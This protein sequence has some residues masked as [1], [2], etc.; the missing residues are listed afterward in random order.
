MNFSIQQCTWQ[1]QKEHLTAIRQQVFIEGQNISLQDEYDGLD[2]AAEHFLVF[3]K[4]QPVAC[5]RVIQ[6]PGA[7]KIG[8]LAVIASHRGQGIARHL[9]NSISQQ[10]AQQTQKLDAQCYLI[11]FYQSA[12]FSICGPIFMDA[13][14]AHLPM[15]KTA[16]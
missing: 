7:I 2:E 15:V 5:A 11:H 16:K 6:V 3:E 9:L 4:L 14:I 10:F 12:G 8:R 13:G 1:Q